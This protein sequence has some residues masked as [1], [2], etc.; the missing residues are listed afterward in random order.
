[1]SLNLLN[2]KNLAK[3]SKILGSYV[4]FMILLRKYVRTLKK[5]KVLIKY[6]IKIK[7]ISISLY[8]LLKNILFTGNSEFCNSK[9]SARYA[10]F[11]F[12]N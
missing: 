4:N 5:P 9:I 1:M 8:K 11:H 12:F 10:L 3:C 7:K 6:A 2:F